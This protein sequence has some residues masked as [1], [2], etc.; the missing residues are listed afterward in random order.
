MSDSQA[1][2]HH[3]T[4]SAILTFRGSTDYLPTASPSFPKAKL[5]HLTLCSAWSKLGKSLSSQSRSLAFSSLEI[6]SHTQLYCFIF[7]FSL[8]FFFFFF[9]VVMKLR[10]LSMLNECSI[11]EM[12]TTFVA[13]AHM[14]EA[15]RLVGFQ[16]T[17]AQ[18]LLPL[19]LWWGTMSQQGAQGRGQKDRKRK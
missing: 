1:L 18:P 3:F 17:S 12:N 15:R 2:P 4:K 11:T 10:A 16:S 5:S 8:V 13:R 9:M 14:R 19:G 7:S 6:H